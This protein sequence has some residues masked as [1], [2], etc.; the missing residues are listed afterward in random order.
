MK[1]LITKEQLINIGN[2]LASG[3]GA[4]LI[5]FEVEKGGNV[6]TFYMVEYGEHFY[7][8]LTLKEIVTDYR[9]LLD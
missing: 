9:Y 2:E 6:V 5:D 8:K 7:S 3:W 1:K 4:Q